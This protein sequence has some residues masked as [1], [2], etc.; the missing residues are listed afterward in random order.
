MKAWIRKHLNLSFSIILLVYLLLAFTVGYSGS[1]KEV[2]QIIAPLGF[3]GLFSFTMWMLDKKKRSPGWVLLLFVPLGFLFIL[4]INEKE[5]KAPFA[6][7]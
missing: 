7:K 2:L 6:F 5:T 3:P 4:L 1:P